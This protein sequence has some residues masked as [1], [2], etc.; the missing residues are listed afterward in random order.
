VK[1]LAGI[2][3]GAEVM[4][5]IFRAIETRDPQR[6]DV[7]RWFELVQSDAE[8]H[9]PPSLPYGGTARGPRRADDTQVTWNGTW[10]ALQ[11]TAAERRMDPRVVASSDDEVVILWRQRGISPAGDRFE[12]EVLGLYRLR[13]GKLARA[14]MFYFD[15]QAA[16]SF[17]AKA[18]GSR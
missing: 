8:F 18:K 3:C 6:V 16:V 17:L 12:G 9:W 11:P 15:T 1:Y 4:L 14:Q 5:E 10:D 2:E 13:E 7:K